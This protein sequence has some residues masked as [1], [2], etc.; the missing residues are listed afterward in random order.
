MMSLAKK[1]NTVLSMLISFEETRN[2]QL[3]P[4]QESEEDAFVLSHYSLLGNL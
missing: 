4:G 1:K 2:N 3:E